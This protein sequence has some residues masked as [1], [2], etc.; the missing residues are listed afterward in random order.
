MI[1]QAFG[2]MRRPFDPDLEVS[3]SPE[4]FA[5]EGLGED[6]S[7]GREVPVPDSDQDMN[8]EPNIPS[9]NNT[10][11]AY[12]DHLQIENAQSRGYLPCFT[13][14][15]SRNVQKVHK[16]KWEIPLSRSPRIGM[17]LTHES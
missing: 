14:K 7:D 13:L 4:A 12:S 8:P 10:L 9:E 1:D 6:R 15:A 3:F 5:R 17:T 2:N 11:S 16:R